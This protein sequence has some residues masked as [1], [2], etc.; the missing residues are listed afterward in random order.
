MSRYDSL[1]ITPDRNRGRW[2]QCVNNPTTSVRSVSVIVPTYNRYERLLRVVDAL[3]AQD[4]GD[5]D[6]EIVIVSDGSSDGTDEKVPPQLSE[7]AR[8]LTQPNGGPAVA[9]NTGIEASTGELLVFIDDDVVPEPHCVRTH[10]EIHEASAERRVVI[11]PLLTPTTV[12]LSPYVTWEQRMLYKQYDAMAEGH[13]S[14]TARQFYTGNASMRR[15]LLDEFGGFDPA[16]RRAE[17]VE[18]GY[19]LANAGVPFEFEMGAE[20]YHFAERSFDSWL[21]IASAY[22]RNDV[23]F[24]RDGGQAW[25]IPRIRDEY[26]SRH[27]LNRLVTRIGVTVPG[28]ASLMEAVAK[29]VIERGSRRRPNFGQRLLSALYSVRYYKALAEELGSMADFLAIE[30]LTHADANPES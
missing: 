8:L 6:Y 4:V 5:R 1:R 26:E 20:A 28:V 14:A 15:S 7:R 22:G 24:W 29:P 9:R 11:G 27:V 2:G 30:P 3:E 12:E 19:R 10:I 17:D 18:L 13:Y 21:G 16:F 23:L 25:L